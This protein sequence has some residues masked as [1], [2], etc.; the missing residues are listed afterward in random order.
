M[1]KCDQC[2]WA[3]PEPTTDAVMGCQMNEPMEWQDCEYVPAENPCASFVHPKEMEEYDASEQEGR[4]G[5]D[6]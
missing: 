2:H 5:L 1:S 6:P 3:I 4:L